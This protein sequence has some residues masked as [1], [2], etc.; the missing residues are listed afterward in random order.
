[1]NNRY[2]EKYFVTFP[3]ILFFISWELLV[4]FRIKVSC[5]E[6]IEK[7]NYPVAE[8]GTVPYDNFNKK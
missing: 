6:Y 2:R 8:T 7:W 3:G 4:G 1:M 5:E